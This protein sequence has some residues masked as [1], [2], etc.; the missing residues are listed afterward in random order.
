MDFCTLF[1]HRFLPR[2]LA[3]YESLRR[4]CGD[5]H[6]YIFAFDHKCIRALRELKLE[7]STAISLREFEDDELLAAKATRSRAEYLWTCT[8]SVIRYAITRFGL[9]AC[10]YLD[11][12]LYFFGSPSVLLDELG[13]GS[14]LITEH[15]YTKCYDQA[16][17]SGKYCV[18]FMTFKN[19]VRGNRALEWW[20]TACIEWCYARQ[21]DGK[22]GDQKYLDD[23]P[24]RFEGVHVLKHLGG[25]V[26][27]WNVQQYS[28]KR[29]N[30]EL[31]GTETRT[32]KEFQ[33]VFCHYHHLCFYRN[34]RVDL[35][36]YRLSREAKEL[37]YRPYIGMV[38]AANMRIAAAVTHGSMI[39]G[40]TERDLSVRGLMRYAKHALLGNMVSESRFST[41]SSS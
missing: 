35:G 13:D 11:A 14:V 37:M 41:G 6:L 1:D 27:P 23:W 2:G 29:R 39:D 7:N 3:L 40:M 16:S 5:F 4:H 20:R 19:D 15:H 18:Q 31:L 30:G 33:V 32:G 26:A 22:F 28:L 10:T 38:Q 21:E 24:E 12:D 34:G 17:D 36:G 9:E 25:G 8:P